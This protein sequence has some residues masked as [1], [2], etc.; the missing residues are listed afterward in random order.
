MQFMQ[1]R[2]CIKCIKRWL[3]V[4]KKAFSFYVLSTSFLRLFYVM[5]IWRLRGLLFM[6][7]SK[8]FVI[9]NV[10]FLF[11]CLFARRWHSHAPLPQGAPLAERYKQ[12]TISFYPTALFSYLFIVVSVH[13]FRRWTQSDATPTRVLHAPSSCLT[14]RISVPF[15]APHAL[16]HSRSHSAPMHT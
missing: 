1:Y 14:H 2:K 7:I 6:F 5:G 16:A 10:Y 4:S 8:C 15:Y 13:S 3:I 9:K 11:C 12:D